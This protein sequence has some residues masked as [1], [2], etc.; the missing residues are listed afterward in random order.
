MAKVFRSL[1]LIQSF[2]TVGSLVAERMM[3]IMISIDHELKLDMMLGLRDVLYSRLLDRR[4]FFRTYECLIAARLGLGI[5]NLNDT[6]GLGIWV[7][8]ILIKGLQFS[9]PIFDLAS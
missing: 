4:R 1:D 8:T 2:Y 7:L 5:L 9:P 6:R 3:R